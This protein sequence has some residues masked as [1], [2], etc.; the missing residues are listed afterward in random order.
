[1][2]CA[3]FVNSL[4][5]GLNQALS[6]RDYTIIFRILAMV[7][8]MILHKT[9]S[10]FTMLEL[11]I[12]LVIVALITG[13]STM[14]TLSMMESAKQA[15]TE[16][17]LD[18][19]E[20]ALYAFRVK[21]NRL[22]CPAQLSL[23]TSNANYGLES[24]PLG[25]CTTGTPAA[26]TLDIF[27]A[28]GMVPARTLGIPDSYMYDG[29]GRR[30]KYM[31]DA[32]VTFVDAF[33]AI[34][35]QE[36]C[37]IAILDAAGNSITGN[38]S[39]ANGAM[40]ALVSHGAN[41]HGAYTETGAL[42]NAGSADAA[43]QVNCRCDVAGM[44]VDA[45]EHAM[46]VQ[47]E[48]TATFDDLVRYKERWQMQTEEDAVAMT[49]YM[50]PEMAISLD[51]NGSNNV[52]LFERQCGQFK[53]YTGNLPTAYVSTEPTVG[54]AFTKNNTDILT[55]NN[56][57][58]YLHAIYTTKAQVGAPGA[59]AG[60]GLS[61][62]YGT[63]PAF[64]MS[65][66][67]FLAI[68]QSSGAPYVN[69]WQYGNSKFDQYNTSSTAVIATALGGY[70][71]QIAVSKNAKYIAFTRNIATAYTYVY[72]RNANGTY[73]RMSNPALLPSNT[74]IAA[75]QF[76]PDEKFLATAVTGSTTVRI[77]TIND[78]LPTYTTPA[79]SSSPTR[80]L[81]DGISNRTILKFSPDGKYFMSLGG[82]PAAMVAFN[83][84]I[85]IYKVDGSVFTALASPSP[86]SYTYGGTAFVD[87]AFSN[88]S[89]FLVLIYSGGA[90]SRRAMIF[91]RTSTNTF[92][93]SRATYTTTPAIT[94]NFGLNVGEHPYRIKFKH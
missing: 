67:G 3:G 37:E 58:C 9:Q 4:D 15:A 35:P 21:N 60:T 49:G 17:K 80:T 84:D 1:M 52:K 57:T 12:V 42:I 78:A 11:S 47:K 55:Y 82:G 28:E 24:Q 19:I 94:L 44:N 92:R 81:T 36:F 6:I 43:E 38:G 85:A 75:M 22:P 2:V 72:Y 53:A 77:W 39:Y 66:S 46:Y 13:M 30:I 18:E 63:T 56:G 33:S 26:T 27:G 69:F 74:A 45:L 68:A 41:G 86:G 31:V 7:K 73:T 5:I 16:K 54:L 50:G 51:Q 87:A 65:Q 70:P 76:S 20:R 29:W 88:D 71:T 40:Y 64:D 90:D 34:K 79:L 89:H 14:A 59:T 25:V 10:G 62:A 8:C 93:E 32:N 91:R 61:C 23:A 48:A 83:T